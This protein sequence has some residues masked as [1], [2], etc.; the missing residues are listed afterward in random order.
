MTSQQ[1]QSIPVQ[2]HQAADLF[3]L[4]AP[5][6]GME[7]ADIS[8]RIDGERVVIRGDYRGSRQDLPEVLI[9]EWTIGPYYREVVL[10]EAVNGALTNATYGNGVLVLSMPR[11]VSEQQ[12]G[13][14]EF[15]L[16]A[17]TD[18]RGQ[19]IN[20]VGSALEPTTTRTRK[21]QKAQA[22]RQS[23]T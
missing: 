15:R 11:L 18:T 10:P 21:R 6:P 19:Y 1:Q 3:V 16:E 20:H 5:M 13:P 2:I 23:E 12:R 7:P 8:V 9:S 14:A 4:A 22:T 17:V